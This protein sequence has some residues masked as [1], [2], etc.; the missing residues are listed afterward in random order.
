MEKRL[1]VAIALSLLVI[2]SFQFLQPKKPQTVIVQKPALSG[3][4]KTQGGTTA[5]SQTE[6]LD[7]T[8]DENL[9]T[10]QTDK[11]ILTFSNI[12]GSVESVLLKEYIEHASGEPMALV[13]KA[14]GISAVF[15]MKSNVLEDFLFNK[16]F[17]LN[18][19]SE[20]VIE[21]VY[22]VPNKFELIKRY[23]IHNHFDYIELDIFIRNIGTGIIYKDYDLVGA[24]E[25]ESSGMAGRRFVEIDSMID[26][27]IVRH[28]KI[29]NGELLI[30]GIVS[31]TGLKE[32]YF[33]IILKPRQE[34]EG[35]VL[36]QIDRNTLIAGVRSAK[37]PISPNTTTKDSYLL[38]IGP[39]NTERLKATGFDLDQIIDYGF[40]GG[41]TKVLLA[42]LRFFHNIL[43]NWGVAI[44]MLTVLINI[45]LFPLTKKSFTS[46]RKIQEVQPHIEK[47]RAVHKDNPQKLNKELAELYRQYNINPLGGCLPLLIQMPIF[48]ALYQGLMK[49]IELKNAN[50]LWIKDLSNPDYINLPVTLPLIGNT[51]HLLPILMVIA[52][53]FQQKI[54]SQGANASPEQKQQ[55]KIMLIVFPIFF[56]FLFYNFPS[57]LVLYWLTNTVLMV[58]EQAMMKKKMSAQ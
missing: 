45:I 21:Y 52:M 4:Q 20:S 30:R 43:K 57:G 22:S 23:T 55:Q 8:K 34:S 42:I 9:T 48:I 2:V 50:F 26:G 35:V 53:F 36:R 19:Q 41:I 12:G 49:S 3:E 37:E 24:S 54:S 33:S 17:K 5:Y 46:M 15:A 39:N 11:Y 47:L 32:R 38:Y 6:S 29:K 28:T 58:T 10:I 51:I 14:E 1:I 18:K 13:K 40:F 44:I 31:W 7:Y 27:K 16:P 56:G 25:I